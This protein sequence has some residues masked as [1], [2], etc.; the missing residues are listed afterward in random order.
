M[1]AFFPNSE[2]HHV[3]RIIQGVGIRVGIR[4]RCKIITESNETYSDKQEPSYSILLKNYILQCR[5]LDSP[6]S[7]QI[8]HHIAIPQYP[9]IPNLFAGPLCHLMG[10]SDLHNLFLKYDDGIVHCIFI[11]PLN[12]QRFQ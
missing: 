7:T 4:F 11:T 6:D 8:Q 1:V 2:F 9:R 3:A 10:L 5:M 12:H